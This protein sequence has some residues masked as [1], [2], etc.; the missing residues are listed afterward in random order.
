MPSSLFSKRKI[1]FENSFLFFFNLDLLERKKENH[2]L[3][4]ATSSRV[5]N[6]SAI[7]CCF[8]APLRAQVFVTVLLL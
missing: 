1:F 2:S 6:A 3:S 5:L 8:D 4:A 7:V